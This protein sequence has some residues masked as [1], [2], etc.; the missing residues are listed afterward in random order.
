MTRSRPLEFEFTSAGEAE[1]LGHMAA[2]QA[3]GT[4]WIN[5]EPI[6]EEEHEPPEPGP[7]AFL[8]G[9]T[10]KVP[11]AT[12]MPGRHQAG[13]S[14]KPTTVGLQHAAGPHLA[15]KLRDLGLPVPAEWRITQDHPKR[16]LVAV[17]PADA[18]NSAVMDWLLRAATTAC[19]VPV[20]GRWRASV[21]KGLA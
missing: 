10:H 17:V 5:V 12:W 18:D 6:I 19:T 16:G 1:L 7:F 20:T 9:S 13:G 2:V 4:G 11:T 3:A 14:P 8:G 21:H 15:W